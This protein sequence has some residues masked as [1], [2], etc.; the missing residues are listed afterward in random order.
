M[1]NV[2]VSLSIKQSVS[3][4]GRKA[5]TLVELLVVIGI[6]AV[7]ISILLPALTMARRAANTV[8]CASN[9]RQIALA[10]L[11]YS[12]ESNG[13][14]L[15]NAWTTGAFLKRPGANYSDFKCPYLC[16]TWDWTAPTAQIMGAHFDEGPSIASRSYRFDYLSK[17][18][19]FRC[20]E[21]AIIVAPYS[22]SPI[23]I[24][25]QMV[26]Y[27]TALMFQYVYGS[28]DVAKFQDFIQTGPYRPNLSKVGNTSAKIYMT[29][30]ARWVNSDGVAPDYNLGWDNSG[31]SPGGHYSDYG[32]WSA[33]TRSFLRN[34]PMVYAMRHGSLKPSAGLSSYRFNVSFFDGHVETLDGA[35]GM[36][37]RM[38]LPKGSRLPAT[39]MSAEAL[40]MYPA[41]KGTIAIN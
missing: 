15:G 39:E 40:T 33:F 28:G 27:D 9:L 7:L 4:A 1:Q 22:G 8:V 5:F 20:P 11:T 3:R 2:N 30:A 18:Q 12:Q 23:R 26:S 29:D 37:P 35:T 36:N 13:A 6:I 21:N 24:T 25:T 32:P 19:A 41:P 17:Y 10:M 31:S 16:Q 34:E 38:W 14:I